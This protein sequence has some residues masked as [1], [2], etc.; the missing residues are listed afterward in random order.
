MPVAITTAIEATCAGLVADVEVGGVEIDVGELDVID[1]GGRGTRSTM[2]SSPA[3]MRDT[4]ERLIPESRPQA[5][6]TRSSTAAGGDPVDVGLHH[7]RVQR[8]V[9][10]P[11][12]VDDRREE[13]AMAQLG[14]AQLDVT[15]LG[16][17]TADARGAVAFGDAS[18]DTLIAASAD[19]LGGFDLD[20]L[21]QHQLHGV[22]DQIH[23]FAGTERGRAARTRQTH[24][25]PSVNFSFSASW[26]EHT[27]NHADGPTQ[28]WTLDNYL[29]A[30]HSRGRLPGPAWVVREP[31]GSVQL[32]RRPAK[33][34]ADHG[35][36]QLLRPSLSTPTRDPRRHLGLPH[37]RARVAA[38]CLIARR[39]RRPAEP[40]AMPLRFRRSAVRKRPSTVG[41]PS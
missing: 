21:L 2:S 12:R 13:A 26:L 15:G 38:N 1:G 41:S 30:H 18:V 23:S 16:A 17:S 10:P 4:S 35:R 22:T 29:K 34:P 11:P 37:S 39:S 31:A 8:L 32:Q 7:H 36:L 19:V 24:T 40:T 14:D 5:L 33:L 9:D 3:Q 20:Q 27:E 28:R 6:T 25:G